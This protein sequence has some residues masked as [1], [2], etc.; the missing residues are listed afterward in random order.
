[1]ESRDL[2]DPVVSV[3][4]PD[5]WDLLDSQEPQ[6]RLDVR[7]GKTIAHENNIAICL[8][9]DNIVYTSTQRLFLHQ[10]CVVVLGSPW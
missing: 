7:Y 6:A 3:D 10:L 1:M 8:Y 5:P 9:S 4:L 2:L